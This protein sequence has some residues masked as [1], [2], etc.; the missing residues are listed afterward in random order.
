MPDNDLF[1]AGDPERA[2]EAPTATPEA[3]LEAALSRSIAPQFQALRQEMSQL[4]EQVGTTARPEAPEQLPQGAPPDDYTS[5]VQDPRA[6]VGKVAREDVGRVLGPTLM[7]LL[8]QTREQNI[9]REAAN[10]DQEYGEGF[11]A[12]EIREKLDMALKEIPMERQADAGIL[13][14]TV[15]AIMGMSFRDPAR[16]AELGQK[17][18]AV[19]SKR[20][21]T[22]MLQNGRQRPQ[23]EKNRPSPEENEFVA[24]LNSNGVDISIAEYVKD[25]DTP[26]TLSAWQARMAAEA[27]K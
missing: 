19:E 14:A 22:A 16:L 26:G 13:N 10:I 18:A 1:N 6:F 11:F 4:R 8:N 15:S 21:A 20:Q 3:A 25:R 24:R 23:G 9:H 7:Q 12:K 17:R 2:G 5:L 27:K